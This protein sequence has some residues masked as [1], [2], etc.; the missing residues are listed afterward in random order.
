MLKDMPGGWVVLT[1]DSSWEDYGA[2]WCK[3][4]SVGVWWVLRFENCAE[5]GDGASGYYCDVQRVRFR[6]VSTADI[7]RALQS[8]GLAI[9]IEDGS[10]VDEHSG[11]LIAEALTE[12]YELVMLEALTSYG[13]YS[14][15]GKE[16]GESYPLRVRAAAR[17]LAE[18]LMAD[19]GR[20][21]AALAKPVNA[22]GA[23]AADFG[24]GDGIGSSLRNRAWLHAPGGDPEGKL[25]PAERIVLQMYNASGG[26]TL[27]GAVE[28]ELAAAGAALKKE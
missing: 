2:K 1:G 9:D 24:R 28:T 15:M 23:T 11:D 21:N 12:R 14:P 7:K 8:C 25:T 20:C 13:I 16:T 22:L 3:K 10:I 19:A 17:R 18:S 27:G 4:D 26:Q 5:W 6:D